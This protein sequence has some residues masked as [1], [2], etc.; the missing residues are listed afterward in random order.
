MSNRTFVIVFVVVA[1]LVGLMVLLHSPSGVRV[2]RSMH[3]G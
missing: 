2:M 3:G 1:L